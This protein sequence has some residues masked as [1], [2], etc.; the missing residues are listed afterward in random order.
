MVLFLKRHRTFFKYGKSMTSDWESAQRDLETAL[1]LAVRYH[2]GQRDKAG[3]AYMLHLL[4]VMMSGATPAAKQVG[5]LHDLLEDTPATLAELKESGLSLEVVQAI[6]G[7]TK[8]D[9]MSYSEY[10]VRLSGNA[11]A[12]EVKL[13][14][15]RDNYT[16]HRVPYRTE[17]EEEDSHRIQRYILAYQFL[18][19]AID[20]GEFRERMASV[21]TH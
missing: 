14:D 17:H 12:R 2:T 18:T 15:L 4:R 3:E 10:I 13:A 8:P 11:L 19:N 1:R 16:I 5:L 20:E 6:E 21:D 7:L 9:E